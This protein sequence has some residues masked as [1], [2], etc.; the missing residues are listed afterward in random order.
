MKNMT[1]KQMSKYIESLEAKSAVKDAFYIK[2]INVLEKKYNGSIS[3]NE[4]ITNKNKRIENE[5]CCIKRELKNE[6][7]KNYGAEIEIQKLSTQ[8]RRQSDLI[9]E[10]NDDIKSKDAT[11]AEQAKEIE[12]LNKEIESL[13]KEIEHINNKN[14]K[15]STNSSIAPSKDDNELPSITDDENQEQVAEETPKKKKGGVPGHKGSGLKLYS[16][17]KVTEF[18]TVNI[19]EEERINKGYGKLTP[20]KTITRQ[21][22]DIEFKT[23]IIN[24]T[25]QIYKD[26]N[27]NVVKPDICN[28]LINNVTYGEELKSFVTLLNTFGIVSMMNCKEIVAAI[29]KNLINVSVGTISNI[30][31][32]CGKKAQ[33]IFRTLEENALTAKIANV[34]ETPVKINGKQAYALTIVLDEETVLLYPLKSRTKKEIRERW[35]FEVFKGTVI[36][37]HY[38][39]YLDIEKRGECNAHI[40]RYLKYVYE[41]FK[42]KWA[43]ELGD[44]FRITLHERKKLIAQGKTKFPKRIID[45]YIKKFKRILAKAKKLYDGVKKNKYNCDAINLYTR[46]EKCIDNHLLFLYDFTVPFDNN[47]AERALRMLKIK[48][49]ES[50]Q[51]CSFDSFGYFLT[52]RSIIQ[53]ARQRKKNI[54]HALKSIY[55]GD[56]TFFDNGVNKLTS[57]AP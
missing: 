28:S 35:V 50:G 29:T 44:L 1:K 52:I 3:R 23:N 32:D 5:L 51:F 15:D 38:S 9:C 43:E 26:E 21:L 18:V 33:S 57:E 37:D 55:N 14:A 56:I 36:S 19:S 4:I 54:Y 22:V 8:N 6:K 27:G 48:L 20:Y 13:K 31:S 47:I 41:I 42:D 30:L 17:D 2:K 45:A 40:L 34:D 46:I 49:K 11:I 12:S 10:K 39:S 25:I 24:Y 7:S 16:D 53:T